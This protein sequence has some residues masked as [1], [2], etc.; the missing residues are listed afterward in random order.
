MKGLILS[1][2]HDGTDGRPR[3]HHTAPARCRTSTGVDTLS[4]P[5][6]KVPGKL[7]K[8]C[9]WEAGDCDALRRE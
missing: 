9:G 2:I 1:L 4:Y 3:P 5:P 6:V 7:I 8:V